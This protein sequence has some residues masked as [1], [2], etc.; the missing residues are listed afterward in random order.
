MHSNQLIPPDQIDHDDIRDG[1]PD[2]ALIG[3]AD[4]IES[5]GMQQP[6]EVYRNPP[7]SDKPYTVTKG[8]RRVAACL[9]KGIP[10]W[11]ITLDAP[12]ENKTLGQIAENHARK[13][14]EAV[15]L[16]KAVAKAKAEAPARQ[17]L[18]IAKA[19][20][21]SQAEVSKCLT[22]ANCPVTLAA[23][24]AGTLDG[25]EAAYTVAKAP[26][27][28]KDMLLALHAAGA[29]VKQLAAAAKPKPVKETVK[30]ER[31]KLAYPGGSVTVAGPELDTE[32]LIEILAGLLDQV[33]RGSKDGLSIDSLARV[34]A[35][36]S[37]AGGKP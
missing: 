20:G 17:N 18:D 28:L 4:S 15:E 8:N 31:V 29:T 22:V 1:K 21:C 27:A 16:V 11:A 32:R 23:M 13:Q 10:V 14:M 35:D 7:G 33:R 5:I 36:R 25:L 9:L 6:V 24:D 19:T 2:P 3:L 34:F 37:K 30:V 12:P 26:A